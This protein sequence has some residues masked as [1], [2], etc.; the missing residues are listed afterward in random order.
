MHERGWQ[1][2][3]VGVSVVTMLRV[4]VLVMLIGLVPLA[5]VAVVI[6]N[7]D[8]AAA[9]ARVDRNL[10]H[11]VDAE[12]NALNDY[13]DRARS[14]D[15]LSAQN[16]A[17]TDFYAQPGTLEEKIHRESLTNREVNRALLY[18]ANLYPT[19]IGEACLIDRSGRE[20]AREVKG[21][22]A[23]I[24]DLSADESHNPFFAGTWK[25]PVG[26]V[27]Q[28]TPYVSPDTHEW[29]I[30]NSTVLPNR[31]GFVHFEITVESF[32]A[33]A[34]RLTRGTDQLIA[35]IDATSGRVVFRSDHPQAVGAPLGDPRERRF[36]AIASQGGIAGTA[37]VAGGLRASYER[38]RV[39]KSNQND[40]YVVAYAPVS[41][42]SLLG[43]L[44]WPLFAL[45]GGLLLLA[46]VIGRRYSATASKGALVDQIRQTAGTLSE[47]AHQMRSAVSG[48]AMAT[49]DQSAAVAETSATIQEMATTA[50]LI[51]ENARASATAAAQTGET[52]LDM[53]DKVEVIAQRSVALRD[54]SS[55]IDD[56]LKLIEGIADQTN[57]LALNAAIEAARAG[58][59]GAGFTVVASE[60]R[61]LAERS[62]VSTEN[63]RSIIGGVQEETTATILATEQGLQ[64]AREVGALMTQ[65]SG[66]LEEAIL[67]TQQQKSAAD[68][69]SDAMIQIRE[70]AHL[71]VTEQEQRVATAEQIEALVRRLEQA[72]NVSGTRSVPRSATHQPRGA[73]SA[74]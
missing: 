30:S 28:Q 42:P 16:P 38:L 32:R 3:V 26:Q 14:I 17:F 34:R 20:L 29:V 51:A 50:G 70:S 54:R 60:V 24:A 69:V 1:L 43:S 40:W 45:A 47:L 66:A 37:N 18:I 53:Q 67:A 13:F 9:K 49:R 6:H 74:D 5:V 59:A 61:K 64:H 8:V 65:T 46:V 73:S 10:A 15:L 58:E 12:R 71:L 62:L 25:T 41:A 19:T 35:V 39:S 63:I 57:L 27:Y 56:I 2:P 44:G 36:T 72:L 33:Q 52:M 22:Q 55:E 7:K 68:Q 11:Q 48:A 21:V 4:M 23:P 31:L